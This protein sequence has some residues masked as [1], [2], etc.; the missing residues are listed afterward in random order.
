MT[1]IPRAYLPPFVW[2]LVYF[3][4]HS[5]S[6]Y[7]AVTAGTNF[8]ATN[9][10]LVLDALQPGSVLPEVVLHGQVTT[11]PEPQD[12]DPFKHACV[13]VLS[14]L[15]NLIGQEGSLAKLY[16]EQLSWMSE[17]SQKSCEIWFD[18]F[19]VGSFDQAWLVGSTVLEQLLGT[20]ICS[21]QGPDT[22]VPFLVRDLLSVPCLT[23]CIPRR[24]IQGLKTMLG[25][26]TT[27]N[28]RNLLW[29]GFITPQD[30]I[31]LDAYGAMLLAMTMTIASTA[32]GKLKVTPRTRHLLPKLY[33]HLSTQGG[34][35]DTCEEDFHRLYESA[36]YDLPIPSPNIIEAP[37]ALRDLVDESAFVTPGTKGQWRSAIH[38]IEIGSKTPFLFVM[39]TLPLIEHSLRL[40]FVDI[41]ECKED[42]RAALIAGEYY[43]TLDVILNSTIPAEFFSPD[44]PV[45][46]KYDAEHIPNELFVALGPSMVNLLSDLFLLPYGPRLRDRTSHGELNIFLGRDIRGD[47]WFH[48]YLGLVLHL[49][50][51]HIPAHQL[52]NDHLTPAC[53]RCEDWIDQYSRT[54]FDEWSA[55]KKEATQCLFSLT[56]YRSIA[57]MLDDGTTK[58]WI[59]QIDRQGCDQATIFPDLERMSW[60]ST[61]DQLVAC[62]RAWPESNPQSPFGSNISAWILILQSIQVATDRVTTKIATF[63][64]QLERRQLSS[65][66]RRQFEQMRPIIP[67]LLGMLADCLVLIEYLVFSGVVESTLDNTTALQGT[68]TVA[69][70]KGTTVMT[71][72]GG[73]MAIDRSSVGEI[74]LRLRITT[75][76]DKF[77]S[78]F[79]RV[80]LELIESAW[81]Q[82]DRE[83]RP[84]MGLEH[85]IP[86]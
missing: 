56:K 18:L 8:L 85:I 30:A 34:V 29:H 9:G 7:T 69:I 42:R 78:L 66:A 39:T 74:Q 71:S 79:E 4:R 38:H 13:E 86:E 31:P 24:L 54:R 41:N 37:N 58:Q 10:L 57:K 70:S 22:F 50:R 15:Q 28:I 81:E 44:S 16:S 51:Q 45:L 35:S 55:L 73:D 25:S 2:D 26:P 17:S 1:P 80:K 43:V 12:L 82:M 62:A 67:G 76:V 32:Q 47:P 84:L 48:C 63:T 64:E 3:D 23:K 59:R 33:Y 61:K 5:L 52:A 40:L 68:K 21:L 72:T 75:F 14:S 77:V 20:I 27:L 65:R 83:V 46:S 6:S 53:T 19:M 60:L 11:A 36:I 49:F